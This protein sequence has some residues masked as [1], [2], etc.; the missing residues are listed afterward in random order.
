MRPH[1]RRFMPGTDGADS[2]EGRGQVDGDDRVPFLDRELLDRRHVLDA[3]IVDEN[4]DAAELALGGADHLDDLGRLGHVG[5]R[6]E[7]LDLAVALDA[8][9]DRLD[10]APV[11]EAIEHDVGAFGGER[12]GDSVADAATW[13]R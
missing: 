6:I 12:P 8:G 7:R 10:L 5:R 3:G 4:V 9:A 13:S 11:A 2:V 1:L